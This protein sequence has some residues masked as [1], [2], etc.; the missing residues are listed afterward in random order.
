MNHDD[1][2]KFQFR[3]DGNL[4]NL[5][6]LQAQTK[7][8]IA[9]LLE[10]QY[11]DDC[12]VLAHSPEALQRSL[13]IISNI[14]QSMG[15]QINVNKTEIISQRNNPA[16]PL[17]FQ[18]NG[19][20]IKQVEKFKYL[21]SVLTD[22]HNIDAEIVARINQASAS[23]GR[24]R[25]RVFENTNLTIKTKVSVYVAVCLSTLLYG[26]ESWT[27]YQRHIKQL[28][29]FHIRCLQR[30]LGL[31]WQDKVPHSDI[32][33]RARTTSIEAMLARKQLRWVGHVFRMP[34]H[35][36]P[37]QTLYGQLNEARRNP[38]GQKKRY[39]DQIRTTMKKCNIIPKE[40]ETNASD[41]KQWR[42]LCKEGCS[43]LEI[44]RNLA[45][46]E[47]R[48]RRHNQIVALPANPDLTCQLC[49]RA[50][51]SRIGFFSHTRWHDRR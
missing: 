2:V 38:G 41:R 4:F 50:C 6:R 35:R 25:S 18:I 28:E 49:G 51:G 14:Y 8:N 13:A 45:R 42:A 1:G 34:E 24:L 17:A 19:E 29:S 10:L 39:K 26:A 27:T 31:R 33:Q 20:D 47:R 12:S 9:H 32:L 44:A 30:I 3:L 22:R 37:R 5:R 15:L 43:Q 40:L 7:T 16:V 46:E 36:L 48:L 23:F 11:A 21:G